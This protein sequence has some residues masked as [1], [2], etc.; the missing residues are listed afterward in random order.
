MLTAGL[1]LGVGRRRRECPGP[2]GAGNAVRTHH[3]AAIGGAATTATTTAAA[4]SGVARNKVALALRGGA[5]LG[6]R[7]E[8]LLGPLTAARTLIL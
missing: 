4:T 2:G 8:W 5:P 6:S 1:A 3:R 7:R